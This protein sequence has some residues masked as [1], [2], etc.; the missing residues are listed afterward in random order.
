MKKH[1]TQ[2][3]LDLITKERERFVCSTDLEKWESEVIRRILDG[4]VALVEFDTRAE[5]DLMVGWHSLSQW[6]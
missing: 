5:D 1:T 4:E 6:D 2:E 3:L